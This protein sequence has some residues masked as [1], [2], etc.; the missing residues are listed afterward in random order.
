MIC[1]IHQPQTFPWLGYFAKIMQSD[2]FVFINNVQFKKNEWQ[3]RNK[4]RSHNGLQWLT[5]PIIHNF[6]QLLNEVKINSTINWQNKHIQAIKT[7]YSKAP[8]F[9]LY[10]QEIE[11]IYSSNWV[12][13]SDFNIKTVHW[14]MDKIGIKTPTIISSEIKDLSCFPELSAE[15]RLIAIT[16]SVEADIYLSGAGGHNYLNIE[17]FSPSGIELQFQEFE[18]PRYNQLHYDFI[19]HTSILDLIFNKGPNSHQII[20]GGI[21]CPNPSIK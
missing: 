9:H 10:F 5:I 19:S 20:K 15:E 4:I 16:K 17:L 2:I 6:G 18:H 7:C 3:N 8:Y 13:L 1:S 12:Y 21:K 14:I 11:E